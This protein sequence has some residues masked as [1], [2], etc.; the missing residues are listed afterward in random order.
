M[1]EQL[2][3]TVL[4]ERLIVIVRGIEDECLE[5]LLEA[6]YRGGVR[7]AEITFDAKGKV[8][9]EETARQI[10]QMR[11][12]FQGKMHIGAGTV[13]TLAQA[14]AA[15]NAG[16]EFLISPNVNADVI[17]CANKAGVLSMPGAM[18]PTE[19]VAAYDTGADLVKIFPSD[20]LGVGY[21]KALC[22]PLSHIPFLAVGG[23]NERNLA[24]FLRA[25]AVGVGV[26][27]NIVDRKMVA[28]GDWQ[29]ITE[30][31]RRYCN[32]VRCYIDETDGTAKG[33]SKQ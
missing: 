5:P 20:Q 9:V 23:V 6:M 28:S 10:R 7:L 19:A 2:M 12:R 29:G 25:G 16:A 32:A 14:E 1:K 8:S 22:A 15:V 31:A 30:V 24:D 18:T 13:L 21:I 17:R 33:E 11:K 27:G 4:R 26:G 3:E